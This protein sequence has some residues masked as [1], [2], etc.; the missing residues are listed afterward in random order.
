[1][2]VFKKYNNQS[3]FEFSSNLIEPSVL[4]GSYTID[5]S[6]DI[7]CFVSS[8]YFL[9]NWSNGWTEAEVE[10]F[11]QLSFKKDS[12]NSY[13]CSSL[14]GIELGEIKK[15]SIKFFD[16][17]YFEDRARRSIKNK[18]DRINSMNNFVR[19]KIK[20]DYFVTL[21]KIGTDSYKKAT[22]ELFF[23]EFTLNSPYNNPAYKV[24]SLKDETELS[25]TILWNKNYTREV[26]PEN[27]QTVRDSGSLLR[28]YEE[29]SELFF[30]DY[31]MDYYIKHIL[32]ELIFD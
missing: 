2:L 18:L 26:F 30:M 12:S 6:G 1:M 27:L 3:W 20:I 7:E 10:A 22:Y 17:Y 9:T 4:K 31:N 15:G 21:N 28:D 16:N 23:P 19:D 29:S 25:E 13:R 32:P 11:G 24:K 5:E 14:E 8:L